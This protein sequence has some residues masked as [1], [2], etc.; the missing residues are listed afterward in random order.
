MNAPLAPITLNGNSYPT[1]QAALLGA[2]RVHENFKLY[3]AYKAYPADLLRLLWNDL[4]I[5]Q[6]GIA[7]RAVSDEQVAS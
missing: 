5:I 1:V 4:L 3:P 6:G 2:M 7:A